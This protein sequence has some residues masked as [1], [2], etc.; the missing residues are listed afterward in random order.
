MGDEIIHFK[1]LLIGA[2]NLQ[3]MFTDYYDKFT[4]VAVKVVDTVSY[5]K[6]EPALNNHTSTPRIGFAFS[7]YSHLMR[8]QCQV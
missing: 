2:F 1:N 4:T 6:D 8:A 3:I 5:R 7:L